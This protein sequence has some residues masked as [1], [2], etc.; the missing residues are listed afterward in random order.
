MERNEDAVPRRRYK[1][2]WFLLAAVILAIVL[3]VIWIALKAR[4]IREERDPMRYQQNG[5]GAMV[6]A[7]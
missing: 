5:Y 1:W 3:A 2:P 4:S 6:R 7:A